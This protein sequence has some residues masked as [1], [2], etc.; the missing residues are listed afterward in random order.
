MIIRELTLSN[1]GIYKGQHRFTFSDEKPVVLIGALNGSGKTTFLEA[2]L[3]ALYGGN[4]QAF[5]E[6]DYSTLGNYL[7]AHTN[8]D[9][10]DKKCAIELEF[11]LD[12][13]GS[14]STFRIKRT[15]DSSRSRITPK[16]EVYKDGILDG[17]LTNNWTMYVEDIIPSAL[18]GF[19]FFDGEKI[20][21]LVDKNDD[22]EQMKSAIKA[23]LGID[24]ID[25][26]QSDLK[27]LALRVGKRTESKN[28]KA[29]LEG[30]AKKKAELNESLLETDRQIESDEKAIEG[31]KKDREVQ[32]AKFAAAGGQVLSSIKDFQDKRALLHDELTDLNDD[33]VQLA[34][35]GYPLIMLRDLI[36]RAYYAA[37]EEY[38]SLVFESA[39]ERIEKLLEEYALDNPEAEIQAISH[40]LRR[41]IS[42]KQHDVVFN[43]SASMLGRADHLLSGVFDDLQTRHLSLI[44]SKHNLQ[45]KLLAIDSLLNADIDPELIE[46]IEQALTGI[47]DKI[48]Q[49]KLDIRFQQAIR[50]S[51]NG[52]L[53]RTQ[54]EYKRAIE[55]YL[56]SQ[57]MMEDSG[58]AIVYIEKGNRVLDVYRSKLQKAKVGKLSQDITSCFNRLSRKKDLITRV[59]IDPTTLDFHYYGL[60]DVEMAQSILSA[61][62]RQL[63]VISTL[64]ALSLNSKERLPVIIDTPLARLDTVHRNSLVTTY[65]PNASKQTI[66][67]STDSEVTGRS[68][69]L[70]CPNI[71]NEFTLIYDE[72]NRTTTV[73]D[74]YLYKEYR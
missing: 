36:E 14:N 31:L 8:N 51:I 49:L 4:S 40:Y 58:R 18:S 19:F 60:G 28:S 12:S 59:E 47:D 67:L 11:T 5:L 70:L 55:E 15:W 26:L 41:S 13:E 37:K 35:T 64:W 62:E 9:S 30:L 48:D 63:V 65:F 25:S 38:D 69:E 71:S 45:R 2:I 73:V 72:V 53:I 57:N 33:L 3:F 54:A 23:L 16:I 32:K 10:D 22:D 46:E 21:E 24:L 29:L 27:R 20:A 52:E 74:G 61:G 34:S 42:G 39:F 17:N 7:R 68:Y 43:P 66:I 56:T 6:S 44:G 1:F 50:P